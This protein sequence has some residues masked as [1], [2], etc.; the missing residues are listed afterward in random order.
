MNK[1]QARKL[2]PNPLQIQRFFQDEIG[3]RIEIVPFECWGYKTKEVTIYKA[4]TN[5]IKPDYGNS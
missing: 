5:P 3:N 4:K 1:K 2:K